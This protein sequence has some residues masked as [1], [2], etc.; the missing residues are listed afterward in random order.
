MDIVKR[1]S[2][3]KTPKDL[4]NGSIVCA[5]NI[6]IDDTASFITNDVSI[7]NTYAFPTG[8]EI[9]GIIPCTNEIVIFTYNGSDSKIYRKKDDKDVPVI[10]D[11][12]WTY[13]GGTIKGEYTYNYKNELIIVVA[14]SGPGINSPLKSFIIKG[15]ENAG[16]TA[17]HNQS[18]AIEENIPK[19]TTSSSISATGELVCGVYTFFIRFETDTD[20]YTKWFQ[21]SGDIIITNDIKSKDYVHSYLYPRFTGATGA[22]VDSFDQSYFVATTTGS[23]L[24][25]N[26]DDISEKAITLDIALSNYD[27]NTIQLGYIIKR[28]SDVKARIA[29]EYKLT[30]SNHSII[31]YNNKF[32][33]ETS[34]DDMLENPH[35]FYNVENIEVYN[36]RLYIANYDEYHNEDLSDYIAEHNLTINANIINGE[37]K[38][39]TLIPYQKYNIFCHYIRK[40]GSFTP[41][42]Y[43]TS[44]NYSNLDF[45]K[46]IQPIFSSISIPVGYIGCFFTYEDVERSVT[47]VY[48]TKYKSR[49]V[50]GGNINE[51][52]LSEPK[53]SDITNDEYLYDIDSIRGQNL[54]N[55]DTNIVLESPIVV[56]YIDN[57]LIENHLQLDEAELTV[58]DVMLLKNINDPSYS[59][60]YKRL[61]RLTPN[62]YNTNDNAESKEY[63]PDFYTNEHIIYYDKSGNSLWTMYHIKGIMADP[64]NTV[65]YGFN[66]SEGKYMEITYAVTIVSPTMYSK[67]PLFAMN[68]KDDFMRMIA[69]LTEHYYKGDKEI[70][71]NIADQTNRTEANLKKETKN[72]FNN[73]VPPDKLHDFLEL[74]AAYKAE[75]SKTY[76]NYREDN[77]SRFDKTVYRS[78]VVSD[79]SL[80]N[81]FRHFE[82]NNYKNILENKGKITNIVGIGLYLLIH[83]EY[84][85]FVFDR[86]P[87]LTQRAQLDIPDAFDI[88]YQEVMP[89]N[90]GFGGLSNSDESIV[91]KN[92]YIWLDKTN[93]YIF[94]YE[95]GQAEILSGD[96]NNFLKALDINT[97]RFAEDINNNRLII[98]LYV[99]VNDDVKTITISYSFLTKTF[100]SFHDYAFTNNYRTYN[101]SYLVTDTHKNKLYEFSNAHTAYYSDLFKHCYTIDTIADGASFVDIIFNE[102]Y[103]VPKSLNSIGYVLYEIINDF[104]IY[105]VSEEELNR[106]YSGYRLQ[107]Y[108]DETDTKELD[109]TTTDVNTSDWTKPVWDKSKWL[110]NYFRNKNYITPTGPTDVV[111]LISDTRAL[112]YGKY[113]VARFIFDDNKRYKLESISF[114][115]NPY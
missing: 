15:D 66:E 23:G 49:T 41:G 58:S 8:E 112:I 98:C 59:R 47:S 9:V 81:G 5:R 100:I 17:K 94:K 39:R 115:V 74:Q 6:M 78:D 82:A 16:Y 24:I 92:G 10:V 7:K 88:D 64:A 106:R 26:K 65:V 21:I 37:N 29:G 79:E 33:E 48:V 76:T 83:T 50:V 114:N 20:N 75:P 51:P 62:I 90:E 1:L 97:V 91:T 73:V 93:K 36:N 103:T 56:K 87:K 55:D 42:Y 11:C 70:Q 61:Y 102:H 69:T 38:D 44:L 13:D 67:Y 52:N 28:K 25:T 12:D 4:T 84:S 54:L 19:Y 80:V 107:I 45:T 111:P 71:G 60:K 22:D 2:L 85:L 109:I 31:V 43:V 95:N 34:I 113:I 3:N 104:P 105:K 99:N 27:I 86:S 57:R 32:I 30:S 14:E 101:K 110:F 77:V 72:Y 46:V 89:S 40:D 108:T 35:Q 96:I 68:I 53:Y 18:Y 63:L